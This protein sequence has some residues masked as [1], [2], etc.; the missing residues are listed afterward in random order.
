[1][2]F[3]AFLSL[4]CATG[5]LRIIDLDDDGRDAIVVSGDAFPPVDADSDLDC[6]I[7]LSCPPPSAGKATICG[8]IHDAEADEVVAAPDP[9]RQACGSATTSG[10]CS[11]RV[12]FVEAIDFASDPNGAPPLL[13]ESTTID[14]CGRFRGQNLPRASFGFIAVV[15]DDAP[16]V[17]P[18]EPHRVTSIVYNNAEASPAIGRAYTTRVAT[19]QLW[20]TGAGLSGSTFAQ[21]GVLVKV[22]MHR[23]APVAGV[24]VR[25]NDSQIPADD[26]YFSDAGLTRRMVAPAQTATGPNGTVLV[27][28]TTTPIAIGGVGGEPSGCTWPANLGAATPGVVSL[29]FAEAETPAG[30]PCP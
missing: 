10:P 6:A 15:V 11:L 29:D 24:T 16:G 20:T 7:P 3:V 25:R 22:F 5:C 18:A 17:T 21:R 1:M 2:R 8:W 23:G 12:R 27:T 9:M 30:A 13:P 19:D 14:D 28:N 26:H 4:L